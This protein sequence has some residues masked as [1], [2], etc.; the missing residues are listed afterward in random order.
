MNVP[1]NRPMT[2]TPTQTAPILQVHTT[3]SASA[4]S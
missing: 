4:V 2:A 3:V 1:M